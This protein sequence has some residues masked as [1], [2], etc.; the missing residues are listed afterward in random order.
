M[1]FSRLWNSPTCFIQH[2][3]GFAKLRMRQ[4]FM[5]YSLG[6]TKHEM[7]HGFTKEDL[8]TLSLIISKY[9]KSFGKHKDYKEWNQSF[10]KLP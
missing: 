8:K 3:L 6:F 5:I 4:Q 1:I 10:S 7:R 9:I 2:S